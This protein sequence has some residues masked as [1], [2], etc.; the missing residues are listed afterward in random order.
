MATGRRH[1]ASF[2]GKSKIDYNELIDDM[3]ATAFCIYP[4]YPP[5]NHPPLP[6]NRSKAAPGVFLHYAVTSKRWDWGRG[7]SLW[8]NIMQLF[9]TTSTQLSLARLFAMNQWRKEIFHPWETPLTPFETFYARPL[10]ISIINPPIFP[11]WRPSYHDY[12]VE[13]SLIVGSQLYLPAFV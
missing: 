9:G 13:S 7:G 6:S 11:F 1:C 5:Y 12:F 8:W 2:S 10:G 3:N 4:K